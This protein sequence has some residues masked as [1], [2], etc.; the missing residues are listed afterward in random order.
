MLS[1]R[2]LNISDQASIGLLLSSQYYSNFCFQIPHAI[3]SSNDLIF[4][5]K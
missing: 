5:A 2:N 3:S 4:D 1:S